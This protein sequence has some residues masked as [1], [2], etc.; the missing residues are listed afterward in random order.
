M[1]AGEAA[2]APWLLVMGQRLMN[3]LSPLTDRMSHI[4]SLK[5][6]HILQVLVDIEKKLDSRE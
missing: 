6:E 4:N 2:L 5:P 3:E 1:L